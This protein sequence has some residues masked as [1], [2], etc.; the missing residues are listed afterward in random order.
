MQFQNVLYFPSVRPLLHFHLKRD[1]VNAIEISMVN[2]LLGIIKIITTTVY[3]D[4]HLK[5][6]FAFY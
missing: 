2:A 5:R 1:S 4:V 3:N 6:V